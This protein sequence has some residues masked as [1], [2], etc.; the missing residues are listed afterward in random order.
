MTAPK[1]TKRRWLRFSLRTM[2]MAPLLLVPFIPYSTDVSPGIDLKVLDIDGKPVPVDHVN[3]MYSSLWAYDFEEPIAPD[4]NG[5]YRL[6][7]RS[8]RLSLA[9]RLFALL[10]GLFPHVGWGNSLTEITIT[11]RRPMDYE[12]TED[13]D[14]GHVDDPF[15]YMDGIKVILR[16]PDVGNNRCYRLILRNT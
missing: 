7:R 4:S 11:L 9:S 10:Q 15:S 16:I 3:R 12:R 8:V 14:G 13:C 1:P 2:F 5:I 6:P